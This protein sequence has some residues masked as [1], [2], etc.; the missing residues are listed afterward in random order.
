M[1]YDRNAGEK[2]KGSGRAEPAHRIIHRQ[3]RSAEFRAFYCTPVATRFS[4]F[5]QIL[6]LIRR[7]FKSPQTVGYGAGAAYKRR[8]DA[9]ATLVAK[10]SVK[11]RAHFLFV[12]APLT[13]G[14]TRFRGE[15]A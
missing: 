1:A 5:R 14:R 9:R 7:I 2:K 13:V 8:R 6:Q 15:F 3:F 10:A 12:L 4:S 11:K